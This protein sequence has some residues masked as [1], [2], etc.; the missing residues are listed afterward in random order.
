[1]RYSF[2]TLADIHWG[3]MDSALMY[4]NLELVL[5]F[6][7]KMTGQLDFVV[8][9]G[10]YFDYRLQLNSKTA[11]T[12]ISWFDELMTTC[13]QSG[14]KKVRMVKGTPGHDY[15]Q[16]E[17]FRPPYELEDGYFKLYNETTSEEILPGL[18][19]VFCPDEP[20]NLVD[21]HKKYVCQFFPMND[22]G[23]FH[24]SFDSILPD[25]EFNRIQDN[26]IASMIYEYIKFARLIK[27][28]LIS[29]H[30][31]VATTAESLY[32]V[33]SYD[34]WAFDE[35]EPKGFIY[36]EYDTETTEYFIHR[37]ENLLARKYMT[38]IATDDTVVTPANFSELIQTIEDLLMLDRD[39]KLRVKYLITSEE[40]DVSA[41]LTTLQRKFASNS[42]VKVTVKD[43]VVREIK[44]QKKN[45]TKL[46]TDKYQYVFDPDP[47]HIPA[48]IAQ[49]IK[50]K[51]G[52]D[53]DVSVVE[54]Y[55]LKYLD[56]K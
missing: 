21:Y 7:R 28:P 51:K 18:R 55:V 14:V 26:S 2:I 56:L 16:L 37:V 49:F 54:K 23:F 12:A 10:D 11:L 22:I 20:M 48:I 47:H 31:H 44:K 34:R 13:R 29:G 43:L 24:G 46:Q 33:G 35:E 40:T 5:Q 6:I 27:G 41:N 39:T 30:W 42:R 32:Y 45:E 3:A 52:V 36:G 8:I 53:I 38:I 15:D 4:Q 1:M 9:A 50:D 25:I 17:V 19:C